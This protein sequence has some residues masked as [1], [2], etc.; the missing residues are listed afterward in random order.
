M[1]SALAA[2]A[3]PPVF[4]AGLAPNGAVEFLEQGS[5]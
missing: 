4:L 2:A 5:P 1:A 3:A